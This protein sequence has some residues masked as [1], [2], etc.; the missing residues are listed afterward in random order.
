M[1]LVLVITSAITV[2]ATVYM[3]GLLFV[4][5]GFNAFRFLGSCL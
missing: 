2:T 1:V 5:L 3:K 4:T